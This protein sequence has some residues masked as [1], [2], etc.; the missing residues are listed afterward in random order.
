MKD[1]EDQLRGALSK[2]D[3]CMREFRDRA[4]DPE[5]IEIDERYHILLMMRVDILIA[6]Q[7]Y[8]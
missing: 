6:L 5:N 8:E 3:Q 1:M 2:V 7:K 4:I